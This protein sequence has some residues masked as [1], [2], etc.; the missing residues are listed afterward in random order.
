MH[1][2]T[3]QLIAADATTL[4]RY[5]SDDV[6]RELHK[7]VDDFARIMRAFGGSQDETGAMLMSALGEAAEPGE[8]HPALTAAVRDWFRDAF[9]SAGE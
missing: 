5:A 4:D 3:R 2:A 6:F 1:H 9:N 8:P 7:C